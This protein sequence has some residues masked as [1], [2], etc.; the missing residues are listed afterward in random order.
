MATMDPTVTPGGISGTTS[1][2][3]DETM[4][5]N[6]ADTEARADTEVGDLS[7]FVSPTGSGDSHIGSIEDRSGDMSS[8]TGI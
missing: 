3:D 2:V 6:L 8:T 1:Q 7:N 4:Q 5:G